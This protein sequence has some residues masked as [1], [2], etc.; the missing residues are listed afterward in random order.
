MSLA[1]AIIIGVVET[2]L[3]MRYK[4]LIPKENNK[5]KKSISTYATVRSTKTSL[6][7][8]QLYF[9][10]SFSFSLISAYK[11]NALLQQ[12]HKRRERYLFSL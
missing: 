9:R 10:R 7:R 1:G 3:Y 2:V 8:V 6:T 12:Q 5:K 4:L 11:K